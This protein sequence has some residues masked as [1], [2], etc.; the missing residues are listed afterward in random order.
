M[1]PTYWKHT[2]ST[3]LKQ[4]LNTSAPAKEER[5][6]DMGYCTVVSEKIRRWLGNH[7]GKLNC[8]LFSPTKL[9]NKKKDKF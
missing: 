3:V 5:A 4:V 9:V 7:L 2:N 1:K 8:K 6:V